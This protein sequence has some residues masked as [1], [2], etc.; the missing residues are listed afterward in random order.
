VLWGCNVLIPALIST[1]FHTDLVDVSFGNHLVET[2]FVVLD[3]SGINYH[4]FLLLFVI[5]CCVKF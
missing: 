4:V 2:G 1:G 5:A 3:I